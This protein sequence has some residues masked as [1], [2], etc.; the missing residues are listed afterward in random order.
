LVA[1]GFLL[2]GLQEAPRAAVQAD[3][4]ILDFFAQYDAAFN[5]KDLDRL[6]KMYHPDVTIYEGGGINTGWVDYRDNHLGPELKS[7][8]GLKFAHSNI[9]VQT[10]GADAAYVTSEYAIEYTGPNGAVRSG[11]LETDVLMRQ[12]GSRVIRHTHTSARRQ[13][14]AGPAETTAPQKIAVAV[15]A[16]GFT[17]NN[18]TV[19]R[20]VPVE[21][22]FTR[23]VEKTCATEV[24]VPSLNVKKPL[25]LNEAVVI[26]ITPDMDEIGFACGMNMLKGKLVVK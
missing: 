18:V 20:G 14:P 11:G 12:G 10:L 7:F 9:K 1:V 25:P 19:Q 15:T 3:K 17:P 6:A 22:V 26:P 23:K 21:L 5:A 16:E 13:R 2:T 4:A 8:T 24:I